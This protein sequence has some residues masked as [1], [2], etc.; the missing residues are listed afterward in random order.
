MKLLDLLFP[1]R[2]AACGE[3]VSESALCHFCA[4][5]W[6]LEKHARCPVCG[7][8]MTVCRCAPGFYDGEVRQLVR[9]TPDEPGVARTLLLA[10]KRRYDRPLYEFLSDELTP[11]FAELA[12]GGKP[13]VAAVPRGR[14][15]LLE[16]GVDQSAEVAKLTAKKA[17]LTFVAPLRRLGSAEQKLLDAAERRANADKA[18]ALKG[19]AVKQVAGADLL[20]FD[21]IITTGA[22]LSACARLLREAGAASVTAVTLGKTCRSGNRTENT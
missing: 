4:G 2:C 17:G 8:P 13:L 19:S 22:T 3:T 15:A 14:N 10:A 5:K 21:D 1:R 12:R 9:Y 6:E 11:L 7:K 18:Y 20:L 16:T